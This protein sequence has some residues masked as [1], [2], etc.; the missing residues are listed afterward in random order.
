[1]FEAITAWSTIVIAVGTLASIFFTYRG[2]QK[3]T[4]SFAG[5]V[6]AEL[7]LKLLH[8][9]DD[10]SFRSLRSRVADAFLKKLRVGEAEDLFD[11]FEQIG[12]FLRRGL[13]DVEIA[14]SFF[15]HWANLYWVAGKSVIQEKREGCVT[16]WADFEYLYDSLLQIEIKTD[17]RSRF[18]NMTPDLLRAC[19]E[20]EV[21]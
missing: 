5:S 20:E 14:H 3:Q 1:M 18:I 8:G 9:F 16:L 17:A 10:D 6:S 4:Q 19:L 13:L 15:F 12:L 11:F 2:M 21:E 7:A